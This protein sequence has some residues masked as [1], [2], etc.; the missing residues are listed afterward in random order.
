MT[1]KGWIMEWA[2]PEIMMSASPRRMN[3]VAS[4]MAW[5]EAAQA[6]R[7]LREGPRA[8]NSMARWAIVMEG[9]CS[10]SRMGWNDFMARLPQTLV[11]RA[12]APA[13]QAGE[14]VVAEDFEVESAFAA[15]V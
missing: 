3:S 7:Q 4:P 11:S 15:P 10:I 8:L 13:G 6:V 1:P 14:G 12:A 9:S 2:P 5:V